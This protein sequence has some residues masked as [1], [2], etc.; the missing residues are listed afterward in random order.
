MSK[1]IIKF[2]KS[3]YIPTS[4][5][6]CQKCETVLHNYGIYLN[7]DTDIANE[8]EDIFRYLGEEGL[9]EIY[10]KQGKPNY[11]VLPKYPNAPFIVYKKEKKKKLQ[12]R[13]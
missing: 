13:L 3:G 11:A 9:K 1:G 6:N 5:E 12:I 2:E 10:E 7:S 4:I 8:H